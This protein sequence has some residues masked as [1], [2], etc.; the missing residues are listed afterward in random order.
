MTPEAL[1]Q[2]FDAA[3][4][5]ALSP[6]VA[7]TVGLVLLLVVEI[8]PSIAHLRAPL[9]VATIAVGAW[10]QVGLLNEPSGEVAEESRDR[11]RKPLGWSSM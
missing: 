7:L 3:A 1:S 8:L 2:F 10:C 5:S 6:L 9:F 11:I 4:M